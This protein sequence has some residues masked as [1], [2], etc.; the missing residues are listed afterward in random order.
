MKPEPEI[1]SIS[2]INTVLKPSDNKHKQRVLCQ[3]DN[4]GRVFRIWAFT[5]CVHKCAIIPLRIR[6]TMFCAIKKDILRIFDFFFPHLTDFFGVVFAPLHADIHRRASHF[7][8][9]SPLNH[10]ACQLSLH[11]PA[12]RLSVSC[13]AF[14]PPH[15]LP[16]SQIQ[17]NCWKVSHRDEQR[18]NDASL[19]SSITI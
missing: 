2:R 4:N 3:L 6:I 1:G 7:L 14:Y 8:Q 13:L 19:H 10:A 18:R 5:L 15:L 17:V 16:L 11:C 12:L 9:L